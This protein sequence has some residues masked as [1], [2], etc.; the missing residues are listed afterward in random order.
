MSKHFLKEKLY[1]I[2]MIT[3]LVIGIL[4]GCDSSRGGEYTFT[5]APEAGDK[6]A[7]IEELKTMCWHMP[8][9]LASTVTAFPSHLEQTGIFCSDPLELD[10]MFDGED[11]MEVFVRAYSALDRLLQDEHTEFVFGYGSGNAK[12]MR[13]RKLDESARN[14]SANFE[15]YWDD[16]CLEEAKQLC[17]TYHDGSITEVCYLDLSEGFA[18][19]VAASET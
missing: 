18:R 10:K 15:L 11:A 7:A 3:L 4:T 12:I 5:P 2:I 17:I 9:V 16:V 6:D 1:P 14:S 8:E 13:I 19:C